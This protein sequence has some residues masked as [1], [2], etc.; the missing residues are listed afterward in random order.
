MRSARWWRF[1][2]ALDRGPSSERRLRAGG[3]RAPAPLSLSRIAVPRECPQLSSRRV[4]KQS[5][6]GLRRARSQ[7]TDGR[8]ADL[9]EPR[10]GG[11]TD[12]PH[13]CDGQLVKEIEFGVRIDDDQSIRLCE[14]TLVEG[15]SVKVKDGM[16]FNVT[17][18]KS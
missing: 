8:D 1:E 15:E 12:A 14:G 4:S 13:Q 3:A 7:L 11:R 16:I 6:D 10:L 17:A 18:D 9:G 2:D 5:L